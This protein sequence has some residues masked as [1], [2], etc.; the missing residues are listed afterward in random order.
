[1]VRLTEKNEQ[2]NW[3]LKGVPW[4][5]LTEGTVITNEMR[6]KLYGAL[7]KLKDYEDTGLTPEDVERVNDFE[8]SQ[9]GILLKKLNEEQQKHA[10]ISSE[11]EVPSDDRFVL[12]S[13]SNFSM[14]MIGRYE[15]DDDG[16][17]NW[18][19]GDCDEQDT[20]IANDL[21]V[22]AWMELPKRYEEE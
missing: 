20:C 6:E 9:A 15:Q 16:G 7:C 19:L 8:R 5:M 22:N 10:W 3:R 14:P 11:Y 17:G 12:M 18:Y 4:K 1:M 13:F 2:G 21:F